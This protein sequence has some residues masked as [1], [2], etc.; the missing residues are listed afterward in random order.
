MDN[1]YGYIYESPKIGDFIFGDGKLGSVPLNSSGDWSAWLPADEMQ[2]RGYETYSCTSEGTLHCTE[3]LE[4]QEYGTNLQY[5]VRF[6]AAI[7][8]TGPQ[9]G[10]SPN[11]VAEC[12]RTYGCVAETDWPF[13]AASYEAF[14]TQPPQKV[15]SLAHTQFYDNSFGHSWLPDTKPETIKAALTY[16]PV[17]ASLFAW[18]PP[19]A[20]GIYHRP[21]GAA[22]CHWITIYAMTPEG[23]YKVFDSYDKT[24][25]LLA[26]DYTFGQAKQYTLHRTVPTSPSPSGW[27]NWPKLVAYVK[28]KLGI[29]KLSS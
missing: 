13:N 24:H 19:D 25:K 16:S 20:Q 26:A 7:S 29:I 5:A 1:R 10:N 27:V 15:I 23:L 6:L 8:G 9:H 11:T 14:Y 28:T 12:L 4:K 2:N 22:D 3:I 17:G 21:P 18:A